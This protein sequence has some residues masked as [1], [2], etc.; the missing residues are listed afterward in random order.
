[1]KP[2]NL[3]IKGIN[4]YVSEQSV[5]FEKLAESNIFGIFGETGSGKTT[6]LDSIILALYGVSDRDVL[7]NIINVNTKDAYVEYTFDMENTDGS[8]TR[9]FIRRDFKLRP[10]GLKTEAFINDVKKNKTI[11]EMP[12]NV[13]AKVLDIIGIGKK[14]FTKCVAL[15]QG[16]FDRFLSDTPALRK[17]T[18]AKLFDLE[19]LNLLFW[20]ILLLMIDT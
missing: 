14:E 17:K 7:Q 20:L 6:I 9:Y 5:D 15:P 1:M 12:D 4:S 18:L 8:S 16:E 3:K 2:I 11:A 19:Q 10:S 13:N